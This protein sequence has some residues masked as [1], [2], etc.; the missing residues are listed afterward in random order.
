MIEVAAPLPRAPHN[1]A[2]ATRAEV[3]AA[4]AELG[5]PERESRMRAS[6]LWH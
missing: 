1:L 6:Q 2:G 3:L 4:V 5:L